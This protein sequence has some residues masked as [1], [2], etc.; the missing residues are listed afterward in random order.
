MQLKRSLLQQAYPITCAQY[1]ALAHIYHTQ[2]D[3][4]RQKPYS[5][6]PCAEQPSLHDPGPD[7]LNAHTSLHAPPVPALSHTTITT[8]TQ[9]EAEAEAKVEA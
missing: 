2:K 9:T 8:H 6:R 1:K 5:Q 7:M 4:Q 3:V